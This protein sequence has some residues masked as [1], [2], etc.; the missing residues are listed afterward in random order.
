MSDYKGQPKTCRHCSEYYYAPKCN[1]LGWV[2]FDENDTPDED[3]LTYA[4]YCIHWKRADPDTLE[5]RFSQLA[6][7]AREMFSEYRKLWKSHAAAVGRIN[8]TRD[9]K[10]AGKFCSELETLGVSVDD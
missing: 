8:A 3:G 5:Q 10:A 2:D 4:D 1:R 6:Q 9:F 7:V